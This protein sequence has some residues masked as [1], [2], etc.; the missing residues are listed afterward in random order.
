MNAGHTTVSNSPTAELLQR[1]G[2]DRHPAVILPGSIDA[3]HD[4]IS[5]NPATGEPIAAVKLMS[6]ADY[7]AAVDKAVAAFHQWRTVPAPKRG[8]VVRQIGVKLRE[9]RDDLGA[10]V[11]TEMGKIRAEGIGEVQECID[12][13]DFAVG[14][15]RQLYGLTMPSERPAHRLF[16]Q[17]HPLGPVG[18]ITAF[19][20]PIA[21]YYWN[22]MLAAVC[23]NA[24]MWKP[25]RVTPLTAIAGTEVVHRVM[26]EQ[27]E[28]VPEG[29]VKAED[30]F[31]LLLG[32]EQTVAVP[33]TEDRRVPLISATGS[34]R[35]G[36]EVAPKVAE[37]LGRCLLELGGN[38][39]IVLMPDAD[40]A[41]ALR[42]VVF[43]AVGT[44]GQRCTTTRRLLCVGDAAERIVPRLVEAY[45]T[46]TI[47]DPMHDG[48]LMGPLIDSDAVLRMKGAIDSAVS[49]GGEVL[50]GGLSG[51][52]SG[53]TEGGSFV[54]PTIIRFPKGTAAPI[55]RE[56][57][58]APILYV[59]S[60][61][62]IDEAI[63]A[64][65]R[66]AVDGVQ[67]EPSSAE[68]Y[69]STIVM[70][71]AMERI[72][73]MAANIAEDVIYAVG[74]SVVRHSPI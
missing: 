66:W 22:A 30:L 21:V 40:M 52:D 65:F 70:A 64:V 29:D 1:L 71:R 74:G 46:V 55:T 69:F 59:Y 73:D 17:W 27:T 39:A 7:D 62:E 45:K 32:D 11:T 5:D 23:G 63:R 16:E 15:S 28:W 60:Y 31:P 6:R 61:S 44:A 26:R 47:G 2:V 25:S 9:H 68:A 58:F 13:A 38:N 34:C 53:W 14:L 3:E 56:E 20:F 54:E 50:T 33:M 49:Q 41:L 72:G 10:L 35:M 4:T 51:I 12:I 19:N 67:Q 43:G 42:G 36:R 48:T 18:V 24:V 57:T 37:R 8:E